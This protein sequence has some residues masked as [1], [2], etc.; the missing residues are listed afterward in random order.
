M[1][2]K[3]DLEDKRAIS[4]LEI[5][6]FC[7]TMGCIYVEVSVLENKGIDLLLENVISKCM[8]LK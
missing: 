6:E 8:E 4:R 2:N 1:G 7:R 3:H 5:E